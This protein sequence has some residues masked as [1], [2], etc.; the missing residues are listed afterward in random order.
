MATERAARMT[1]PTSDKE[2]RE[3]LL[4]FKMRTRE[5]GWEMILK[6]H[7]QA[8][9]ERLMRAY[10]GV[11]IVVLSADPETGVWKQAPGERIDVV[12]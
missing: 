4:M 9:A 5:S 10:S 2:L 8:K 7:Q 12:L 1:T 3:N 11:E 6:L